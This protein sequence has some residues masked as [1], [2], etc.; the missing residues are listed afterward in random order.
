MLRRWFSSKNNARLKQK[1]QG[2]I[3][4]AAANL[5]SAALS[6]DVGSSG[7]DAGLPTAGGSTRSFQWRK[8]VEN[9]SFDD[10]SAGPY[11]ADVTA[12]ATA[13]AAVD[14]EPSPVKRDSSDRG[15]SL[16]ERSWLHGG[17]AATSYG[18]GVSPAGSTGA[19]ARDTRPLIPPEDDAGQESAPRIV[20]EVL[21]PFLL[22]GFGSV[23]AG[24]ILDLVQV[25]YET[26]LAENPVRPVFIYVLLTF[27]QVTRVNSFNG[28]AIDDSTINIIF[29]G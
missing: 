18:G 25:R 17:A 27:I 11:L 24:L 13:S 9:F 26:G 21:L 29:Q 20:G 19:P 22:A 4:D 6:D 16:D 23:F 15:S 12:E 10:S 7:T 1:Q 2:L 8:G 5:D 3:V 14:G 28:F